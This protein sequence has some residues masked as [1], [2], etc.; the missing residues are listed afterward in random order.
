MVADAAL[1][2]RR[3]NNVVTVRFVSRKTYKKQGAGTSLKA[4]NES[5]D[6][7][8]QRLATVSRFEQREPASESE[9]SLAPP[10]TLGR[11]RQGRVAVWWR[12]LW[13]SIYRPHM[14]KDSRRGESSWIHVTLG[15]FFFF[16]TPSKYPSRCSLGSI[17]KWERKKKIDKDMS[18]SSSTES[19]IFKYERVGKKFNMTRV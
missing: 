8:S 13:M 17:Q 14:Y 12:V 9:W 16:F 4:R 1:V 15:V 5:K 7:A 3:Y 2:S 6:T 11:H 19:R 18:R 10:H